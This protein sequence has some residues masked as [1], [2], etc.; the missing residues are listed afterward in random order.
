MTE[1]DLKALEPG[2]IVARVIDRTQ[3]YI[4]TANYGDRITA[5]RSVDLTN[6]VEWVITSKVA[7]RSTPS[8]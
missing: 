4:V 6:P 3:T 8:P 2:D 1:D 5:V 7:K